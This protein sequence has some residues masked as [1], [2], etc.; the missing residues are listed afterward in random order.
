M[1]FLFDAS[2]LL[3]YHNLVSS[4]KKRIGLIGRGVD[5]NHRYRVASVETSPIATILRSS[6]AT[7]TVYPCAELDNSLLST[8]NNRNQPSPDN[9]CVS[10]EL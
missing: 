8:L 6:S 7:N 4:Q 3:A 9:A 2:I 10:L 5:S 1:H